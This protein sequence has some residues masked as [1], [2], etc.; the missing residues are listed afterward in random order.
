MNSSSL[1]ELQS[2][3]Y[4]YR[5]LTSVYSTKSTKFEIIVDNIYNHFDQQISIDIITQI[6]TEYLPIV[7][8][9]INGF[10]VNGTLTLEATE[11]AIMHN[12]IFKRD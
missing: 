12:N 8:D 10:M 7:L 5:V 11:I 1:I 3:A 9:P 6:V 4:L 2:Q